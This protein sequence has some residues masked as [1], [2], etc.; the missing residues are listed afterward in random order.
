MSEKPVFGGYIGMGVSRGPAN[1]DNINFPN[2]GFEGITTFIQRVIFIKN[3]ILMN[4]FILFHPSTRYSPDINLGL[5][6]M[7]PSRSV[8]LFCIQSFVLNVAGNVL[9]PC[10]IASQLRLIYSHVK[11]CSQNNSKVVAFAFA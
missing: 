5:L 11:K 7:R 2:T 10:L 9:I 3:V 8:L 6:E 1:R 4:V